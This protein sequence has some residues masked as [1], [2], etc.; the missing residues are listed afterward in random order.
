MHERYDRLSQQATS[1]ALVA[2]AILVGLGALGATPSLPLA[3][4][5]AGLAA[6]SFASRGDLAD[7]LDSEFVALHAEQLW[8]GPALA[9]L[10]ML[11]WIDLTAGELQTVGALVGLAG[12]ANYLLR[13]LLLL[14][15]STADRIARAV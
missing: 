6:L 3:L 10:V 5:A 14:L 11:L 2:S 7:R 4:G 1:I 8:V 15:V 12:M 13:P 9:A